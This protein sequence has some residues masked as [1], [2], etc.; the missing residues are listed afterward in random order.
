LRF[1]FIHA[2]DLHID[3]PFASLGIKDPAVA[4]RFAMAGRKT[5]ENLIGATIE[6]RAAFLIIAGDVFD[7]DWKD[8]TT[9]L[10]FAPALGQLH[11]A[12]I[13]TVIIK[14]NHDADSIM[15]KSLTYPDSV[16]LLGSAKAETV[17]FDELRVALHGRS[18]GG[19]KVTDDFVGGYPA[20]REG[21]LNIGVLHTGLD[22]TR[23]HE[24]YAP[25]TVDDLRRFGYDYWA[26]G[27]IHAAEIV[28]RDPWIVYPGNI[29]GRNVRETGSK[30][31]VRVS[32]E[33]GRIVEVAPLT[34]DHTRWAHETLDVSDCVH[35]ADVLTLI[36]STLTRLHREADGRPLAVRFTLSGTTPAHA[37]FVAKR[38]SIEDEARALGFQIADD[39]WVEQ[40]KLRTSAPP[41]TMSMP[42]EP[43]APDLGGRAF[44]TQRRRARDAPDRGHDISRL[45]DP[46]QSRG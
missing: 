2:A 45:R 26:L 24:S 28:S 1:S 46:R 44:Q 41:R 3:S 15:S 36:S 42:E 17:N 5:V 35:Q 12:G 20:R 23:G 33:D 43:D 30:G 34:L 29:Q 6:S 4:D 16:R 21:W 37:Q 22:G 39:C 27:H 38:E 11:R 18:F 10:F 9:G 13:P 7:G 40:V 8:I 14:G 25:C 19:R 32:V 31:A